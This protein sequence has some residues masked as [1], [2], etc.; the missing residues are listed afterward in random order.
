[1]RSES[2]VV[3]FNPSDR[4]LN[5]S[6]CHHVTFTEPRVAWAESATLSRDGSRASQ[7]SKGRR[8]A[9]GEA[10]RRQPSLLTLMNGKNLSPPQPIAAAA[11][12]AACSRSH[13]SDITTSAPL[14]SHAFSITNTAEEKRKEKDKNS[15]LKT[16]YTQE[17][18]EKKRTKN[19]S[20]LKEKKKKK[21]HSTKRPVET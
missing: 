6:P 17:N 3:P 18:Q 19:A 9:T 2:T 4:C 13:P 8:R 14:T 12:H 21:K 16:K 20:Y 10:G 5:A 11:S 1:M 15:R 7:N